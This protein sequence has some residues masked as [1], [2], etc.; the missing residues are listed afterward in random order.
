MNRRETE[1]ALKFNQPSVLLYIQRRTPQVVA[2]V[3]SPSNSCS[4][5]D[6]ARRNPRERVTASNAH[7]RV[8][9]RARLRLMGA[10]RFRDDVRMASR[11][12]FEANDVPCHRVVSV[13]LRRSGTTSSYT[14]RSGRRRELGGIALDIT[15]VLRRD[16]KNEI[17]AITPALVAMRKARYLS[18]TSARARAR[19]C[20]RSTR[21]SLSVRTAKMDRRRNFALTSVDLSASEIAVSRGMGDFSICDSSCI[22]DSFCIYLIWLLYII[23]SYVYVEIYR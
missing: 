18:A 23:D 12:T 13:L 7:V 10:T 5:F 4:M 14:R 15:R 11:L 21:V 8:T 16:E 20:E 9:T 6:V 1:D 19:A 17:R 2:N 3:Y 22:L